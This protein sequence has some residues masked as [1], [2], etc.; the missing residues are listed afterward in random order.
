MK[1]EPLALYLEINNFNL[2]FFA[3]QRK[4]K[5]I[6]NLSQAIVPIA[7][8]IIECRFRKNFK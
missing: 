5:I 8:L 4:I 1:K 2:I 7:F 6:L 3:E